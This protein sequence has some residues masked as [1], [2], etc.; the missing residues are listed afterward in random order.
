[1]GKR[2]GDQ[3]VR[4]ISPSGERSSRDVT[5]EGERCVHRFHEA[6]TTIFVGGTGG[7]YCA[8]RLPHPTGTENL[9]CVENAHCSGIKDEI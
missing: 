1:M 6:V 2:S 5:G 3:P 8:C 9:H 7:A 4:S